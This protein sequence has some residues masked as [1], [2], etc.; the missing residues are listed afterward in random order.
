MLPFHNAAPH[1][2]HNSNNKKQQTPTQRHTNTQHQRHQTRQWIVTQ[3]AHSFSK[4]CHVDVHCEHP[5]FLNPL[6]AACQL[7]NVARP[8]E[9]P[10]DL[11]AAEEDCRL[12]HPALAAA[13]GGPLP[14]DERRK[15]CDVPSNVE[16]IEFKPGLVY[17]FQWYQHF[18]DLAKYK[19]RA[20]RYIYI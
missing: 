18:F 15:W 4:T 16:G 11:Y 5:Y 7:V 6:L 2:A 1:Q 17:T 14:A 13:D 9:A 3:I 10:S 12:L 20:R 19:V 8:G